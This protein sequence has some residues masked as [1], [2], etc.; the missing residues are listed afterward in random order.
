MFE[1]DGGESGVHQAFKLCLE[2]RRAGDAVIGEDRRLYL[3]R[4]ISGQ[5]LDRGRAFGA[6]SALG[7]VKRDEKVAQMA[8]GRPG[9]HGRAVQHSDQIALV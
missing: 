4:W 8:G 1:G 6:A 3:G 7:I 2:G 5:A 9:V